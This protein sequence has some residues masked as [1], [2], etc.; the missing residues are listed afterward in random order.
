M[1]NTKERIF[2]G[3]Y[4]VFI[5]NFIALIFHGFNLLEPKGIIEIFVFV[6]AVLASSLVIDL[7]KYNK[8]QR[9]S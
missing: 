6:A 7:H 5:L 8:E 3:A 4:S 9:S 2:V 1:L